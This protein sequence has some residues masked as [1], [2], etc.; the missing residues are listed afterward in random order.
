MVVAQY[1]HSLPPT[2]QKFKGK[3]SYLLPNKIIFTIEHR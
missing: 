3:S 2:S 1:R